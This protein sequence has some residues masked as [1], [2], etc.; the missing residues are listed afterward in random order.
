M[1]KTP[2]LIDRG[3][4]SDLTLEVWP[5]LTTPEELQPDLER[6]PF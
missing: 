6:A 2:R 4:V 5:V 1:Y 3:T